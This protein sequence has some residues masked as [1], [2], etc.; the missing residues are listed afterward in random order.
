MAKANN[1]SAIRRGPGIGYSFLIGIF[2]TIVLIVFIPFINHNYI[3]PYIL[4]LVG[5]TSLAFLSSSTLSSFLILLATLIFMLA[6]GGG[7]IFKFF[8]VFGVLGM[9]AGYYILGRLEE[10]F[11]P[12][13]ILIIALCLSTVYKKKKAEAAAAAA[14]KE[15]SDRS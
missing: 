4:D 10:A 9:I 15:K 3:E 8:G 7:T 1:K 6:L 14:A 12:V 5:N 11:L 2:F 13:C